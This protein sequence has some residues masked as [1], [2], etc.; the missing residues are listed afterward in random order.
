[1]LSFMEDYS[2]SADV[3]DS[4]LRLEQPFLLKEDLNT[5]YYHAMLYLIMESFGQSEKLRKL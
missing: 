1:M 4:L 5:S 2:I 3:A